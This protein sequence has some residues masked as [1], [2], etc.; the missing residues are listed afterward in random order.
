[1]ELAM[2]GIS[3]GKA[4]KYTC[5]YS[6]MHTYI[7]VWPCIRLELT[8]HVQCMACAYIAFCGSQTPGTTQWSSLLYWWHC[9][10]RLRLSRYCRHYKF[11][12]L[13]IRLWW[14]KL[15]MYNTQSLCMHWGMFPGT[16]SMSCAHYHYTRPIYP[17]CM[18][19]ALGLQWGRMVIADC[20]KV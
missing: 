19:V 16:H 20:L 1:M 13:Q 17:V 7:S 9:S 11:S 8:T 5:A 10:L 2:Y 4:L 18:C 3:Y 12:I 15:Y 6:Y 14:R